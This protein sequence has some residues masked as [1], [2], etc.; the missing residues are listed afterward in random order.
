MEK[1]QNLCNLAADIDTTS[2]AAKRKY[3]VGIQSF[4]KLRKEG[5]VY[6]DKTQL[7]Y[8]LITE[9]CPY[10]LSRPR[11]FGKSLLCSTLEAVFLGK[12]ELF[13][14]FTTEYGIEQPQL[15]I[16]TTDWKWERHPVLRFDF[17]QG[18][19]Y[20]LQAL[21]EQIENALRQYESEYA[22]TPQLKDKSVRMANL[23]K[24]AHRQT[25]RQVVV[26]VDEYD[27]FMLHS[28]GDNE[29]E[30]GV[31]K[32]FSNLFSPLKSLDEHL[33][34]IFI[35]GISKFS[36]MGIFSTLNQLNNISM[37]TYYESLCGITEEE[38]TT[39]LRT[40]IGLLAQKRQETYDKTLTELK[41]MYDGYHFSEG[42]TDVYN[43]FSLVNAFTSGR[44]VDYWF[45]SATSTA[46]IEMLAKM[47]PIELTDVDGVNAPATSFDHPFNSYDDP[48]P[49]L[50]QSGYITIKGYDREFEDYTLG[51]P[52]AEVCRGFAECLY[53]H[54]TAVKGI[55]TNR[56][57][58]FEAYK[59]FRRHG[60]LDAFIESIKTFFAGV[61]YLLDNKNE[62]HYHALLYT[63]LVIFGADV[64]AE[65]PTSR[66]KADLVLRMP[67]GIYIIELKYDNTAESALRQIDS[68]GYTRKYRIDNRPVFKVGIAFSSADRNITEW[69]IEEEHV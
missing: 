21:D 48:L 36:Q 53:Q 27:N 4:E 28:I 11:R 1:S 7:I 37:S 29:L 32:Q 67:L 25:G 46:V 13:E 57:M 47:P 54:V 56:S 14:A 60:D 49:V 33:R 31:R 8:K 45:A 10:F 35:T 2:M 38:L 50:Y 69:L 34:F 5:F 55:D 64:V 30:E 15:F 61:P 23:I 58:F 65:E 22:I 20:T 16:A 40:D 63:M 43:P 44:I 3:P 17:S 59:N 68:K 42:M 39:Q 24:E 51:F 52:N 18:R 66:G 19:L 12:R 41:R 62:R 9:G 6:V 26:I